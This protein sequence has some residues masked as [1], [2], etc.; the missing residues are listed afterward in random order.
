MNNPE[1]LDDELEIELTPE[2][3]INDDEFDC[4]TCGAVVTINM[5]SFAAICPRCGRIYHEE[6]VE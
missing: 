1:Q 6:V 5:D 4:R 3:A 2:F